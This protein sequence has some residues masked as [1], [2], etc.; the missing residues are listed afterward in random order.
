[1]IEDKNGENDRE[2]DILAKVIT[3]QALRA[4]LQDEF[5]WNVIVVIDDLGEF[6]KTVIPLPKEC[7]NK[8]KL[9]DYIEE[10]KKKKVGD[11]Q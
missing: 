4:V 5:T 9:R 8:E 7:L 10:I 3:V 11:Q 6:G 1:M 2:N